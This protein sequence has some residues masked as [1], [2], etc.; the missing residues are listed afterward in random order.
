MPNERMLSQRKKSRAF[1]A[2]EATRKPS[3]MRALGSLSESI[4]NQEPL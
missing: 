2:D 4:T 1:G 3:Q